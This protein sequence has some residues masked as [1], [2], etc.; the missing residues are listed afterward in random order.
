MFDFDS[1]RVSLLMQIYKILLIVYLIGTGR[2]EKWNWKLLSC[3]TRLASDTSFDCF[4]T[5]RLTVEPFRS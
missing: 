1:M 4:L 2:P 5:N 3:R